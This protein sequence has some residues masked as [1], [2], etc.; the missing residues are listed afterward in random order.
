MHLGPASLQHRASRTTGAWA[1]AADARN[2]TR[3]LSRAAARR[4]WP[5]VRSA[6][7][8]RSSS[9]TRRPARPAS[10]RADRPFVRPE[11]VAERRDLQQRGARAVQ[12]RP[13]P[14]GEHV[15]MRGTGKRTVILTTED[16]PRTPDSQLYLYIGRKDRS[17][18]NVA[19]PQRA[20]QRKAVRARLRR[21]GATTR[22]SSYRETPCTCSWKPRSAERRPA[23]G[24]ADRGGCRR[25]RARSGSSASRTASSAP[26]P[27][28][29]SGSTRRATRQL[30][31]RRT[32]TRT[33]SAG[34]TGCAS[35]GAT[36]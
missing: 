25:G 2:D 11:G 14:E 7:T 27:S 33:S 28:A 3:P 35:T 19:A 23:D 36:R 32:R 24:R 6:S 34:S 22:T 26:R 8:G 30:A 15:V 5:G 1:R 18:R 12:A 10:S 29:S 4:S 16:G 20:R 21:R 9:R 17:S 13:L 31:T